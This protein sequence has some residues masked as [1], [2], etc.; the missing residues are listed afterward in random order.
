MPVI[1][2]SNKDEIKLWI[3]FS[4]YF[5][6]SEENISSVLTGIP[7]IIIRDKEKYEFYSSI[8]AK[9]WQLRGVQEPLENIF[10]AGNKNVY[11]Y[12]FDWDD[13]RDSFFG[14]FGE[15]IGAAHAIEIAMIT[16][17]FNLVD[18][19]RWIVYPRS[20]SRRFVS[21]N[22]MDF[23]T[24]F[25][26]NSVPGESS[27]NINWDSFNPSEEKSILLI[28]EKKN[29]K[30]SSVDLKLKSLV[31]EIETT[32]YLSD[33]E[34]CILLYET[35]N[36]LGENSFDIFSNKV[37]FSCSREEALKISDNNQGSIQL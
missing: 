5:L 28:D 14:D 10:K 30:I 22:M 34:K 23:W 2:G 27:N 31:N 4:E 7:N 37:S 3:G 35:T 9:G 32:D 36:Y 29:L 33:E 8:R 25:A 6:K 26:K 20:P 15:I 24:N 11:A 17:D 1:A 21:K 13:L 16:G 18:E 19:Y 12:R